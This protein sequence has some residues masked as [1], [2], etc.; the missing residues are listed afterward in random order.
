MDYDLILKNG[1]IITMNSQ[2]EGCNWIAVKEGK[3]VGLGCGQPI[4]NNTEKT[5]D[6]EGKTVLP[7]LFD[8]HVH[9]LSAGMYLSSVNMAGARNMKQV[10]DLIESECLA[11][12][13]DSW[14]FCV[15]YL[16]QFI[17][18]H[19]YPTRWE[20]DK[21]SHGHKVLI[22]S[23]TMHC[24]AVNTDAL[25]FCNVPEDYPGV[26]KKNGVITG[27][28]YSDESAILA[29][30]NV[31]G[32]LPE[33]TLWKFI[34]DCGKQAVSNGVTGIHALV[35]GLV[36]E[37][38]D[39]H[40]LLKRS[41]E[42]SV[43]IIPYYQTWDVE[44]AIEL[45]LPRVG[46]CLT[47]DGAAFEHTMAN[48]EPY[49]DAPAL[50]GV[51]YHTDQEVYQFV[52]EAHK[53]DIQCTMH[54]VGERAIDQLLWTYHRVFAE[55]GTKD[56]RHRLEH[57]CLPTESQIKMAVDLGIILSMQPGFT[58]LWDS[59]E[60]SPFAAVLGRE[61]ADRLDPFH[62][63]ID[64]GGILCGGSDSPVSKIE[65]L[66]HI[67][68]C[69]NGSNPVR[70]ISLTNALKLYTIN[71]AYACNQEKTKGSIEIGKDADFTIINKNP[72]DHVGK[73]SIFEMETEYTII[74]GK[75][76]YQKLV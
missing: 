75:I 19:R 42:M 5:I 34:S 40:V 67:A 44:K 52:S 2:S 76:V 51:L 20:L 58:Y 56:L 57:F 73:P 14:V 68:H 35:G 18:E 9:I 47:L 28:F 31:L 71:A 30:S 36:G 59:T 10:L 39:L 8:C 74:E 66:V 54:A 38:K 7:G 13:D 72:Y 46:G 17:G 69:V 63:V 4:A 55:Q 70:N 25:P 62:K 61:R 60:N 50:R 49:F 32:S 21:I 24:C 33:E 22:F 37:D 41:Q 15:D 29:S 65:P 23:A 43:K 12:K 64:A 45:G 6:L 1:N 16:D 3:I 48:Y 27:L 26:L 53:S 11:R